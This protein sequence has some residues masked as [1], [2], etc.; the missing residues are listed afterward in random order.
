MQQD[1]FR[2]APRRNLAGM[3]L[4]VSLERAARFKNGNPLQRIH[5]PANFFTAG[6]EDVVLEIDYARSRICAL[7]IL[8]KLQEV[9][10]VAVRKGGVGGAMK[11]V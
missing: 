3:N 4:A 8:S 10:T 7:E 1:K 5:F 6:E 2:H 11:L 9:P